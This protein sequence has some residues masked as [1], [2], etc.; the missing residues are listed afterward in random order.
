[1][2]RGLR[3]SVIAHQWW[4]AL[5]WLCLVLAGP[6]A[7]SHEVNRSIEK[8]PLTDCGEKRR[9]AVCRGAW[10]GKTVA[11]FNSWMAPDTKRERTLDLPS[12]GSKKVLR[13]RRFH[14][15]LSLNGKQYWTP[16]GKMH[17]AEVGWP[18]DSTRLFVTWSELGKLGAWHTQVYDVTEVGLVE[19]SGRHVPRKS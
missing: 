11:L 13:V 9:Y 2:N 16:F 3:W 7:L 17:D 10:S 1:M 5:V 6:T 4:F 12:S 18:P 8:K 15:R 14:V 19:I